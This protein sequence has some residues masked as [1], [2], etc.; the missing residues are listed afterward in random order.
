MYSHTELM[1][2][3]DYISK[4]QTAARS[5]SSR[6]RRLL[7]GPHYILCVSVSSTVSNLH[8]PFCSSLSSMERVK[9][10][11]VVHG[12]GQTRQ[13]SRFPALFLPIR[14]GSGL[15]EEQGENFGDEW[16]GWLWLIQR[17]W[18]LL[19]ESSRQDD[20]WSCRVNGR[21]AWVRDN[22]DHT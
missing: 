2:T 3:Q 5:N 1:R 14:N 6:P 8:Q 17:Q 11:L 4:L 12:E 20:H 22:I 16:E 19:P 13:D 9:R 21:I 18:L 10:R 15:R 7:T